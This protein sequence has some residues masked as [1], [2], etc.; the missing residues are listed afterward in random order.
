MGPVMCIVHFRYP[1][2]RKRS[3]IMAMSD[4]KEFWAKSDDLLLTVTRHGQSW[5]VRVEEVDDPSSSLSG[6][7]DYPS[8]ERAKGGAILI[9]LELFGTAITAAELKWQPTSSH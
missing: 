7:T 9:A 1:R 5:R 6:G 4:A 3:S 8:V 2:N